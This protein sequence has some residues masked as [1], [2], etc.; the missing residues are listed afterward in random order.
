MISQSDFWLAGL[1]T[2]GMLS[3]VLGVLIVVLILMKRF[4]YR[5]NGLGDGQLITVLSSHHVTPKGR[6]A[7]VDVAGEKLVIGITPENITR[8][9][10]I[11]ESEA[12]ARLEGVTSIGSGGGMFERLLASSMKRKSRSSGS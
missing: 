10:R 6:I 4:L 3:I 11:E 9:G 2:L 8:L 7:L 1:K 5:K 12:L